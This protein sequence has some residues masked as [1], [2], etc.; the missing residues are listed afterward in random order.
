MQSTD[1]GEVDVLYKKWKATIESTAFESIGKTTVKI[2]K[3]K[4]ESV[5]VRSIRAEKRTY[6]KAFEEEQDRD[7]KPILKKAYIKKQKE[8]RKQIE[9]EYCEKVQGRFENMA[10]QGTNGFWKEMKKHKRDNLSGWTGIKD[11]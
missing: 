6:R 9:I 7:K 11:A 10:S 5:I 2:G 8:L 4:S 3:G 1:V